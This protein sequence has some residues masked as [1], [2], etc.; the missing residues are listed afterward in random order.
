MG[1]RGKITV[2]RRFSRFRYD[3]VDYPNTHPG[4]LPQSQ[5]LLILQP[6]KKA[7][8]WYM[9]SNKQSQAALDLRELPL[10]PHP[11]DRLRK[12]LGLIPHIG[13]CLSFP[14]KTRHWS[15]PRNK[16]DIVT[17]WP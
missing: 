13:V 7:G 1:K 11:Q 8:G 9:D 10:Q 12:S 5:V 2:S 6:G 4:H 17:E 3:H 14:P 15:M 16:D